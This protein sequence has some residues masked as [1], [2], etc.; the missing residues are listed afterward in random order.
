MPL[1]TAVEM[2]AL[3]QDANAAESSDCGW[4]VPAAADDGSN[5]M[6]TCPERHFEV[7]ATLRLA[8]YIFSY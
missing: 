2:N 8:G 3:R 6:Q 5:C 7:G 1:N 4:D